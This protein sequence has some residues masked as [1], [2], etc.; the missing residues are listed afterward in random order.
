MMIPISGTPSSHKTK[1]LSIAF[2]SLL[3]GD[4]ACG[5][6]E[7]RIFAAKGWAPRAVAGANPGLFPG[8]C[9]GREAR[10]NLC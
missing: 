5:R 6:N 10:R 7:F 4:N 1:P 2:P 3:Q 9:E 8:S